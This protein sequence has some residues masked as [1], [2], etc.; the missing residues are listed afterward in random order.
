MPDRDRPLVLVSNRGPVTYQE[1]GS[2]KRGT[3]GLVTALTGLA[4]HRDAVWIASAMTDGDAQ[5]QRENGDEPFSVDAPARRRVPRALR[6]VRRR[7]PTT[8]STTSS[9]TRCSGS[10]STTCGTRATRRTSAAQEV[11]A[12][13]HGY[14]V[15]NEDL[16]R[17]RA[18]GD[19]GRRGARR[20]G[21]RLPLLHAA[22]DDPARAPRR[23]PAPLHPHP[24]DAAGRLA[25]AAEGHPRPDLRRAARQRHRR[26]PHA[27]LP[28]Q[29]PAVLPRPDGPR[30]R[31]G[32]GRRA[33]RGPRRVGARLPAADRLRGDARDGRARPGERVRGEAAGAPARV[34][35]PARR[36]RGP[37]EERPARASPASTSSSSSTR[38]S[39]SGS[40]SPRS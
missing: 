34:L 27:L 12:F 39:P 8:A 1:D 6:G 19:R 11:E 15:V 4:S 40:R 28:A 2:L 10:S 24:V 22:G 17:G 18:A 33:P 23:L 30:G 29:L 13:E 16:A 37:V 32:V 38:S 21:P 5:V 26:L 7:P 14:N 35:D 9:P 36:P 3:G 25:R 31:H 20:H